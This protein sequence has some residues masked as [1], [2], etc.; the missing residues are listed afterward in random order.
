[1]TNFPQRIDT[2]PAFKTQ[3]CEMVARFMGIEVEPPRLNR[4]DT[5]RGN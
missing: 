5:V 4:Q 1:M 3:V 2:D